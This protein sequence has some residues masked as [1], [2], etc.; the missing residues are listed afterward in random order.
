[1]QVDV[2][3]IVVCAE[4]TLHDGGPRLDKPVR[5]AWA[6]AV[7]RNPY[8]GRFEPDIMPMMEALKPLGIEIDVQVLEG[9]VWLKRVLARDYE[10]SGIFN[11]TVSDPDQMYSL[12]IL[13]EAELNLFNY[14]NKDCDAAIKAAREESDITKRKSLYEDVRQFVYDEVPIFYI[15]YQSPAYL[16]NSDVLELVVTVFFIG[17]AIIGLKLLPAYQTVWILPGLIIP[18]LQP[19]QVHALMS[20]PRF[21]LVLFP[22]FIVLGWVI[23]PRVIAIPWYVISVSL[24]VLFTAQFALW[25]WVS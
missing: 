14:S 11:E 18:L 7:V 13:T 16:A 12:M 24:L 17:L 25:Y 15:H 1:M 22:L 6:A 20:M 4:E 21:V 23:R 8:A 2:R 10:I 5:K 3:K 19:S 9:S